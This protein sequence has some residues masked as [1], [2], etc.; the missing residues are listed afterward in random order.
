MTEEAQD[1]GLPQNRIFLL[2]LA[3]D[4]PQ[5]LRAGFLAVMGP[6]AWARQSHAVV[7]GSGAQM[8][9]QAL[10]KSVSEFFPASASLFLSQLVSVLQ[11]FFLLMTFP[12]FAIFS[13][14]PFVLAS[15]SG[16][17]SASV[18]RQSVRAF[19]SV[20][21][22]ELSP[23]PHRVFAPKLLSELGVVTPLASLRRCPRV[24]AF[25]LPLSRYES[26]LAIFPASPKRRLSFGIFHL[27]LWPWQSGSAIPRASVMRRRAFYSAS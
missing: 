22:L 8:A 21:V 6:P 7:E 24:R 25:R 4:L 19:R 11:P 10:L 18:K 12:S 3:L 1:P 2:Q 20:L 15:G 13:L 9:R 27:P 23:L 26:A 17:F 5:E 14:Q 16:I